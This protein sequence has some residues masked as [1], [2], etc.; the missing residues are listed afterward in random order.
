MVFA[1]I[2]TGLGRPMTEL[3]TLS[4]AIEKLNNYATAG[5]I[6]WVISLCVSKIAIVAMLLRT[7]QT[8]FHRRFQYGVSAIIVAQCLTSV[9]LLNVDCSVHRVLAWDITSAHS[10]CAQSERRWIALTALDVMTEVLLLFLP[11]QLVW[12]LRMAFRTKLIVISS[13]WLRLPY[14]PLASSAFVLADHAVEP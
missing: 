10:E 6:L 14:V 9:L 3:A 12:G 7:T 4:S 11:I 1:S 5:N 2:S 13:F 8:R